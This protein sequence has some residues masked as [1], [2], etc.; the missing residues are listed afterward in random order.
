M[1][2][3]IT[4]VPGTGKTTIGDYLQ[5]QKGYAHFD[6]ENVTASSAEE[7]GFVVQSFLAKPGDKK[8]ITWGFVPGASDGYVKYLQR[9]GYQMIW[10]DGNRAAA[11][12]AFLKRCDV[13][14]KLLDIQMARINA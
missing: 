14:E 13:E 9:C 11:R 7:F 10:F 4:G 6:I 8:V 12:N 2:V 5:S 1:K 3:L